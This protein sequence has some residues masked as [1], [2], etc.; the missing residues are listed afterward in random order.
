MLIV[1]I[2]IF[3]CRSV[4]LVFDSYLHYCKFVIL[5]TARSYKQNVCCQLWHFDT[6]RSEI[7][8]IGTM[9]QLFYSFV[10]IPA[11]NTVRNFVTAKII[12]IFYF[13]IFI[14]F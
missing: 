2:I 14:E 1:I 6:N 13:T 7:G 8:A 10:L 11:I 5:L 4:C 3:I 9:W 12:I